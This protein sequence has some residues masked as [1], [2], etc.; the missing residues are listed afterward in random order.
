MGTEVTKVNL[1]S[2]DDLSD[3][4]VEQIERDFLYEIDRSIQRN[5]SE[6]FEE[7][8]S[9]YRFIDYIL[10]PLVSASK[11]GST[12]NPFDEIFEKYLS[13]ILV[14]EFQNRG[15]ENRPI[16]YA[17]DVCMESE[18]IVLHIDLKSA[19]VENK[20]DYRNTIAVSKNQFSYPG[21]LPIKV[22]TEEEKNQDISENPI[23]VFPNLPTE[24]EMNG[25]TKLT[26]SFGVL[27]IYDQ[28]REHID[29]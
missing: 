19:N 8:N 1:D 29:K 5:I 3:K 17:S 10:P 7:L 9:S 11:R 28:Y 15:F 26:L 12:F 20:S 18:D 25:K 16:G 22:D 27:T 14:R 4:E 21:R 13:D 23:K 6:F 2:V 24:Y